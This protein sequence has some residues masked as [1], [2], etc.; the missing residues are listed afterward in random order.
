MIRLR[1]ACI[2]CAKIK[3]GNVNDD[4]WSP[5]TRTIVASGAF[6]RLERG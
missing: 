4:P 1:I 6:V 5:I 3:D 2:F